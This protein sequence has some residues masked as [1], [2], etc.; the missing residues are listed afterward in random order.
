MPRPAT[1]P[2]DTPVFPVLSVSG[3]AQHEPGEDVGCRHYEKPWLKVRLTQDTR[4]AANLT[5]E[6]NPTPGEAEFVALAEDGSAVC[7]ATPEEYEV[8][9]IA[10]AERIHEPDPSRMPIDPATVDIKGLHP[11]KIFKL[12]GPPRRTGRLRPE[13]TRC[14]AADH[15]RP[16]NEAEKSQIQ[17][18]DRTAPMRT[19]R[20]RV[21]GIQH[22]ATSTRL[23][24]QPDQ[25]G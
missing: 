17:A 1:S 25:H 5:T 13:R 2:G 4:L 11:L 16:R 10:D 23:I 8:W 22:E 9:V 15:D 18:V 3:H 14:R 24:L 7:G 19:R 6:A 20:D 12:F 21:G